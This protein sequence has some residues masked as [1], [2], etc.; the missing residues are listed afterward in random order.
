VGTSITAWS[1]SGSGTGISGSISGTTTLN[2]EQEANLLAG[3]M[4]YLFST[5]AYVSGEIRGQIS[6][7]A[8]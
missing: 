3:K 4:Y 7:S 6:A 5:T 2:A 1:V 8:Q